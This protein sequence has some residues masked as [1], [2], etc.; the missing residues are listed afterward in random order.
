MSTTLT[1]LAEDT[2]LLLTGMSYQ[3]LAANVAEYQRIPL[4]TLLWL[5]IGSTA[6]SFR[7]CRRR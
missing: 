1:S 6:T 7:C 5:P 3:E 4:A 2:D